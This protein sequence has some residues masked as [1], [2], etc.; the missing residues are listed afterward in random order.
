MRRY[1]LT[2]DGRW[3]NYYF[4]GMESNTD[5]DRGDGKVSKELTADKKILL[6]VASTHH[7]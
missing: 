7:V 6:V 3:D 4:D 1:K 5:N 2:Y